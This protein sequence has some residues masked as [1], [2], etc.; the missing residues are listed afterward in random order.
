MRKP[1]SLADTVLAVCVPKKMF[2]GTQS[3]SPC[4][5]SDNELPA[6]RLPEFTK[7][8][9]RITL[10]FIR[11]ARV[12]EIPPVRDGGN[13]PYK[14]WRTEKYRRIIKIKS[15]SLKGKALFCI[16]DLCT[17]GNQAVTIACSAELTDSITSLTPFTSSFW[18]S[19]TS[20]RCLVS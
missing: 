17:A 6:T 12:T 14:T 3:D 11:R 20:S 2:S 8:H 10:I 16:S 9:R 15:N 19:I 18:V 1:E 5:L 7:K 4:S 13:C